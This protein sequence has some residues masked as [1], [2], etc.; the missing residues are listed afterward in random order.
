MNSSIYKYYPT[1]GDGIQCIVCRYAY[2]KDAPL[3]T[4]QKHLRVKHG[5]S[6]RCPPTAEELEKAINKAKVPVFA[7]YTGPSEPKKSESMRR[8]NIADMLNAKEK[9]TRVNSSR[10]ENAIVNWILKEKIPLSIAT[11]DAFYDMLRQINPNATLPPQA[12][13]RQ[14]VTEEINAILG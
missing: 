6:I 7:L 8:V 5:F 14:L 3:S 2:R 4:L 10:A 1:A 13:L 9:P 11:S 12:R